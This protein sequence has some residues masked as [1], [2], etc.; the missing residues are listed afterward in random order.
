MTWQ[1]RYNNNSGGNGNSGADQ[2]APRKP[3][4]TLIIYSTTNDDEVA[5]VNS[6]DTAYGRKSIISVCRKV[7]EVAGYPKFNEL[8]RVKDVEPSMAVGYAEKI[9]QQLANGGGQDEL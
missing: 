9:L 6:Y 2:G 8:K 4:T 3:A 7:G 5:F 1:K